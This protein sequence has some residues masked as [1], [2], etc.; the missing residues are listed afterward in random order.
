MDKISKSH[1]LFKVYQKVGQY[2]PKFQSRPYTPSLFETTPLGY[3]PTMKPETRG[4][5]RT[6]TQSTQQKRSLP[7]SPTDWGRSSTFSGAISPQP[8]IPDSLSPDFTERMHSFDLEGED[9]SAQK[10]KVYSGG[11]KRKFFGNQLT[12]KRQQLPSSEPPR[13]SEPPR[14]AYSPIPVNMPHLQ[15]QA[16]RKLQ[17]LQEDVVFT[18]SER[19]SQLGNENFILNIAVFQTIFNDMPVNGEI[20]K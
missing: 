18:Q 8:S 17:Y 3:T 4:D 9:W 16:E 20:S 5:F 6:T 15:H 1:I 10:H 7:S 19:E 11:R 14:T 13:A 12:R 2:S